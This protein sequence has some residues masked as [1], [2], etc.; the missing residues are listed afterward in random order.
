MLRLSGA[1]VDKGTIGLMSTYRYAAYDLVTGTLRADTIPLRVDSFSRFLGGVGQPGQLSGH[2]DLGALPSQSNL[3]AALEPRKTLL[4]VMQDGYPVWSGV[5]WDW[6]HSSAAS[7]ELPIVAKEIG[8]LFQ[9]REVRTDQSWTADQYTVI[10][11]LVNYATGKTNGGIAQLVHTTNTSGA[12]SVTA[13]FPAAN[14]GKVSDL[15]S[16]FAAQYQIEYAWDPGLS[17]ANAP[18]ITLRIGAAATMGRPYSSTNLQLMFP[19]NLIDYAWPRTGSAGANSVMATASNAGAG[20]WVSNPAT[21]GLDSADLAAGYPLLEDSIS[22]TGSVIGAQSQ[23][24]AVADARLL[25][26]AKAPT[27]PSVTIAGGQFPTV[28]QIQLGDHAMLAATSSYHPAPA[29]A[30]LTPGLMQDV[31]IIGWTVRP[32]G[33]QP[34]S[35]TLLLGDV[36]A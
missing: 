26:V 33:D 2:L 7:N 27:I 5:V 34:E 22:Y 20:A 21:H 6:A 23:I 11:N 29:T 16:Q 3:L 31:R 36:S 12:A 8:S 30:P 18:I 19:G 25:Q 13:T 4:H 24:D 35:T 15:I 32:S 28:Q 10:R 17:S 1:A 9:R 14:L